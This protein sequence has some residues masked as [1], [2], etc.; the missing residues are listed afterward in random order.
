MHLNRRPANDAG[1][2]S[3]SELSTGGLPN[4]EPMFTAQEVADYLKLDVTTTRR[5]FLDRSDVVKIG[6]QT[7]RGGKRSYVT[8]RIPL[9][10]VQRFIRERSR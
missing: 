1:A 10:A 4:L 9:S 5:L 7:A 6:R 2:G 3:V 8:I